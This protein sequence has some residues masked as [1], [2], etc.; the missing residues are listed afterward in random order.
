V[1]SI[2]RGWLFIVGFALLAVLLLVGRGFGARGDITGSVEVGPSVSTDPG[3]P[4][5]GS[6]DLPSGV[7]GG[8]DDSDG[9]DD[10]SEDSTDEP[11]PV[12]TGVRNQPEG[13]V[14]VDGVQVLPLSGSVG[15]LAGLV[16]GRVTV[17][18]VPVE[19]VDADEGFWIGS[20]GD[21]IWVQLVGP[22]PESPYHV[23]AADTVS[24]VGTVV[25][26]GSGFA[27]KVG[28]DRSEGAGSLISQGAHL[29][30]RKR[31][32]SLSS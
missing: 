31:G 6:A 10:T 28:V 5:A 8:N 4:Y 9:Q 27:R 16:G 3:L 30:V 22:P 21:R 17:R 1:N 32:L 23:S 11:T 24:F 14:Y 7:G 18:A 15:D 20:S 25:A 19:S 2:S 29:Q 26:H 13:T 12:P